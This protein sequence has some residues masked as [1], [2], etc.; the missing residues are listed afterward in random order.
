MHHRYYSY[1]PICQSTKQNLVDKIRTS[2]T[3]IQVFSAQQYVKDF[4][5]E[6]LQKRFPNSFFTDVR[7]DVSSARLARGCQ[8]VNIFVNDNCDK[9]VVRALKDEG[10]RLITL[11]CAGYDR[12]DIDE[13]NKQGIEVARVPSY[14]PQSV[15]EH[16]IAHM[17]CLNRSI[18]KAH[19]RT[20]HG[21]YSLN[22]LIGFEMF[23][24]VV[25]VVGTG[26]IGYEVIRILKGI[27]CHVL[28]YDVHPNPK[29]EALGVKYVS[30]EEMLPQCDIITLHCPLMP[31]TYHL[32][33]KEKIDQMK[34]GVMLIN[35]SRGG[36][37]DTSA[38]FEAL[39]TGKLGS[40]GLDVYENEDDIFFVDHTMFN[41]QTRMKTRS[42]NRE[43]NTLLAYPQ[44]L[45]TPHSAFL[46]QEA[47]DNIA[48][49]TIENIENW[50]FCKPLGQNKINF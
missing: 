9:N 22:G 44:V 28:A 17:F 47:L 7:L 6:P 41:I 19:Q 24:K 45:V 14:S 30:M 3:N 25:G 50:V 36:L 16:A 20:L 23:Q 26:S 48:K 33:N 21:N 40:V 42:Y 32:I 27:G 1:R 15:A 11:R 8:V 38:L 5:R 34:E 39:D 10:V 37:I 2:K 4:L 29:V 35:V 31:S 12:V 46:T 49:T 43:L 13:A 18:N